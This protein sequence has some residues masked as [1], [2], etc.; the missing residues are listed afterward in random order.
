MSYSFLYI[1]LSSPYVGLF[2][3]ILLFVDVVNGITSLISL[4]EFSFIVYRNT[5]DFSALILYPSTLLNSLISSSN[6]LVASLGFAMHILC[7]LQTVKIYFFSKLDFFISFY[8][9]I[10]VAR[11]SKMI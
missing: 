1:G 9:L 5:K 4:S 3:G 2:R 8:S 11:T 7:H 10:A 6:F